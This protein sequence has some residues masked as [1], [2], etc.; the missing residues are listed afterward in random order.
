MS[1]STKLKQQEA[2][3]TLT[4]ADANQDKEPSSELLE[5]ITVPGSPFTVCGNQEMGYFLTMGK[6]RL[7]EAQESKDAVLEYLDKEHYNVVFNL[8][9]TLQKATA[10]LDKLQEEALKAQQ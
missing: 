9:I 1:K 7:S 6:Y 3:H 2:L 10:E 5:R 8:I 4:N